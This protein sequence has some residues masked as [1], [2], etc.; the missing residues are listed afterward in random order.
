MPADPRAK[1]ALQPA[2]AHRH[3]HRLKTKEA[4][5]RLQWSIA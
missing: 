2:C 5:L 3:S 4:M 1:T